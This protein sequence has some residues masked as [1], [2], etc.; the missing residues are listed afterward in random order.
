MNNNLSAF[1]L[2]ELLKEVKEREVKEVYIEHD[3]IKFKDIPPM[4]HADCVKYATSYMD[5]RYNVVFPE[6]YCWN[7]EL[8]DVIAFSNRSSAVIECKVSRSD[9]IK[10]RQKPFRRNPNSGMGDARYYCCPKGLIK[11]DELPYGWGL[12]YVSP[13]GTIR[14]Q[15]E[16]HGNFKKN[17]DAEYHLLFYYARRA[18]NAGVHKVVLEYR[19]FDK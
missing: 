5:K 11:P 14:K 9:F 13:N 18:Y 6:F 7:A 17:K 12:L 2:D 10:D 4:T 1:T 3:D 15:V 8:P 16:S 19:G